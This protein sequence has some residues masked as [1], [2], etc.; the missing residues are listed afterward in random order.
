MGLEKNST[1]KDELGVL[2]SVP[3]MVVSPPALVAEV[4]TG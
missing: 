2:L 3:P 4:S 1:L